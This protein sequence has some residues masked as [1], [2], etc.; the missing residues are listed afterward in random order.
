MTRKLKL[1][2][3]TGASAV[4]ELRAGDTLL[5][6]GSILTARDRAHQWLAEEKPENMHALLSGGAL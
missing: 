1:I 3:P 6:S 2:L 5:L 4:R